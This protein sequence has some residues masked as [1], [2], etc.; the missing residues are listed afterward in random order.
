MLV[1]VYFKYFYHI[2]CLLAGLSLEPFTQLKSLANS[3]K[4][5]EATFTLQGSGK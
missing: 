5:A 3:G 4:L 2:V 1:H